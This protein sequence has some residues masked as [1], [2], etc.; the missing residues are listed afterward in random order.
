LKKRRGPLNV[1]VT[2]GAGY[3]G[4]AAVALLVS[5]GHRVTVLDNLSSGFIKAVDPGAQFVRGDV[6]DERIIEE[7]CRPGIDAVMHFAAFIKVGESTEQPSKYYENNL[8]KSIRL[9]DHLRKSGVN[10]VVYSSSAAVYGDTTDAP[11]TEDA[12]LRP[13]NPYGRTKMMVEQILR[14]YDHA[15]RFRSV[16]LR[17]FNAA[18]A[19]D[20]RGED[21]RPESHLIPLALNAAAS[22]AALAVYGTDYPTRDG[23]CIRDY[24]HV[25]DIA[26]AH[27]LAMIYLQEGG[28][29]DCFNLGTG[30]GHSVIEVLECVEMV[31]GH[32][33][34]YVPSP[35]RE[36][37]SA[38]LVASPRKAQQTLGWTN[39]PLSLHEIVASAWTWKQRNPSGYGEP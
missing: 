37:D 25:K 8:A 36:G 30:A 12:S 32:R 31:T 29:T 20:V 35:R 5:Q 24:V 1:L 27:A 14:D 9:F 38:V 17:Y 33:V 7:I 3:I 39:K 19:C 16:S 2:G 23:T 4:S 10:R 6:S 22:G 15:Y 34:R 26:Q 28:A 18:G 21:H 11:L 13:V